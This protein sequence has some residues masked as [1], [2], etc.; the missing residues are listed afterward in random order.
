MQTFMTG[1]TPLASIDLGFWRLTATREGFSGGA[2]IASRV[3]G[4]LGIVMLL[5]QGTPAAEM[6]AALRWARVPRTWIEIAVL[7][8][9][10]LHVF[11]EQAV[12]RRV[13]A[14]GPPG[15]QQP[16]AIVSIAGEPGGHGRSCARSI[17]PRNRTRP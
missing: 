15:L 1:T 8:Y 16:A 10:Y 5:C 11:F 3:L 13:G 2:L 17:R 4:S 9:R 7:M 12:L 6:F 14:E